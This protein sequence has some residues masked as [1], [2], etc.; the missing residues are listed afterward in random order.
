MK[1]LIHFSIVEGNF[2]QNK[3]IFS[4]NN[5]FYILYLLIIKNHKNK[6]A[7]QQSEKDNIYNNIELFT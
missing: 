4:N 7:T 1:I 6:T 3:L 5:L 2:K